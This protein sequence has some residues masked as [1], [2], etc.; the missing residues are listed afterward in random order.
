LYKT[1]VI[2]DKV[3][4]YW[5]ICAPEVEESRLVVRLDSDDNGDGFLVGLKALS[6]G[7]RS[8]YKYQCNRIFLGQLTNTKRY[9][10]QLVPISCLPDRAYIRM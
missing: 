4:S 5:W 2:P 3:R 6:L 1:P 9:A 10:V 8:Q 7:S